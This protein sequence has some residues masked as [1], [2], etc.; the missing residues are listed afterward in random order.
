MLYYLISDSF[1]IYGK[2][3]LIDYVGP[4]GIVYGIHMSHINRPGALSK[5]LD[6]QRRNIEILKFLKQNYPED[7]RTQRMLTYY[8]P[9]KLME[10]SP[11]STSG[12]TAYVIGKGDEFR[13]CLRSR[14]TGELITDD[15]LTFVQLHEM[16]HI[17][18]V[19]YD[20]GQEFWTNFKW[21]LNRAIE[22]NIYH[23]VNYLYAPFDYCGLHVQ[24]NPLY[25]RSY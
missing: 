19:S 14:Q 8:N 18:S 10:N 17:A 3:K 4:D 23:P 15:Q 13:M 12:D 16:S 6:I 21:L 20:H 1:G 11:Y 9:D 25:D 2:L 24:Y 22:A 7:I 5:M